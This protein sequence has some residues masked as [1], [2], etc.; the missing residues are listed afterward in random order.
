MRRRRSM[1][2]G[3]RD[4]AHAADAGVERGR[5]RAR[6]S[7]REDDIWAWYCMTGLPML[8]CPPP[9]MVAFESKNPRA[10]QHLVVV[11][12]AHIRTIKDILPSDRPLIRDMQRVGE[13]LLDARVQEAGKPSPE[14]VGQRPRDRRILGFHTPPFHSIDHLHLHCIEL[15]FTQPFAA[16]RY[17]TRSL[18]FLSVDSVLARL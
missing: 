1:A 12:R 4:E 14:L 5:R 3:E 10:A 16:W 9:Q 15:P 11:P 18:W 13:L 17:S 2:E 7:A 6:C 8:R